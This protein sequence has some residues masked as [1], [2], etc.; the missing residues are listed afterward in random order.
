ML[1]TGDR[2]RATDARV[3]PVRVRPVVTSDE[4]PVV[5]P[6]RVARGTAAPIEASVS[7][8]TEDKALRVRARRP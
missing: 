4:R 2:Q 5:T 6:D 1:R 3:L 7:G 8:P